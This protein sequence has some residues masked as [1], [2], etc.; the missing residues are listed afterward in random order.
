MTDKH[1][2]LVEM[3]RECGF[4]LVTNEGYQPTPAKLAAFR[5][6]IVASLCADVEPVAWIESDKSGD[7]LGNTLI[8]YEINS[9]CE[10]LYP[11]SALAAL[12]AERDALRTAL[13]D[14][15]SEA[16]EIWEY[17]AD[18]PQIEHANE[19]IAKYKAAALTK[20]QP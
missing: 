2:K 12:A 18:Y 10:P 16:V 20:G 15:T 13:E 19:L 7:K 11:A 3:A 5:D 6:R 9:R 4:S 14:L 8:W 17:P 1:D